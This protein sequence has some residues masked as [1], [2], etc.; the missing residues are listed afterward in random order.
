MYCQSWVMSRSMSYYHVMLCFVH[1]MSC[2]AMFCDV[3]SCHAMLCF[4][5][6]CHVMFCVMFCVMFMLFL[7]YVYF[8][9]I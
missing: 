4:V 3:M 1:V 8:I 9:Y 6:S 7:C 2:H 5:M